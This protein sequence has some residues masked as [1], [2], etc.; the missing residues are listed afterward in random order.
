MSAKMVPCCVHNHGIYFDLN[1]KSLVQILT[2]KMFVFVNSC[3]VTCNDLQNHHRSKV[4]VTN[5]RL[6]FSSYL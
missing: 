5:E 4:I 3:N 1:Q 2:E 6:H